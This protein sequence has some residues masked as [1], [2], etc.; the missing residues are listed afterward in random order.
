M[1][2]I[3]IAWDVLIQKVW[4]QQF[5]DMISCSSCLVL[6]STLT[7]WMC[8][9]YC[10]CSW[11]SYTAFY[12][13]CHNCLDVNI[14]QTLHGAT[15]M[16]LAYDLALSPPMLSAEACVVSWYLII[17][18]WTTYR[19]ILERMCF[20]P[21]TRGHN[22]CSWQL[23]LHFA[24]VLLLPC[25]EMRPLQSAALQ[26]SSQTGLYR[27]ARQQYTL[28][29]HQWR[30]PACHVSSALTVMH[31]MQTIHGH[32]KQKGGCIQLSRHIT[33]LTTQ[34]FLV[35]SYQERGQMNNDDRIHFA[36]LQKRVWSICLFM[37]LP[38]HLFV[39][40]EQNCPRHV[41]F[42]YGLHNFGT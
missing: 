9:V 32:V 2:H 36:Q 11:I 21:V 4:V 39:L 8:S 33:N 40:S 29:F 13:S 23:M 5:H 34:Y 12:G 41:Y 31:V 24:S 7:P 10:R 25:G 38:E 19:C 1:W 30:S 16:S 37:N 14:T 42:I 18:L 22:F 27:K 35:L 15:H 20:Y 26:G 6:K 17:V 28:H 3:A